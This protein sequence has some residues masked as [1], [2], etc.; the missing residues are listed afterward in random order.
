MK[1]RSVVIAGLCCVL[2][3]SAAEAQ[4]VNAFPD[5]DDP[6]HVRAAMFED[7]MFGNHWNEGTIMQHVIFPP[8]GLERPLVGSQEDCCDHT[9]NF[10][11]AWSL[12]YAL[13]GDPAVRERAD[14]LMDGILK[15]EKV[16]GVPGWVA[17]SFNKTE[18]PLWHEQAYFFPMEW[19]ASAS[20]PGYR[21]QGDLSSDK[22][23][24]LCWAMGIYHDF[25]AGETQRKA[26]SDF[27]DRFV[28]RVVD[29]NFRL[30]DVDNKM[31]LWGNFCPD[32][33]HEPL[34]SLEML[35]G[36]R[37]AYQL[38]KKDRY[39]R[40]YRKLIEDYGYAD[41][42][43]MAKLLWPEKWRTSWDDHLAVKSLFSLLRYETDRGLRQKYTM[44][45]NRHWQDWKNRD[46]DHPSTLFLVMNYAVLTKTEIDREKLTAGLKGMWGFDRRVRAFRIPDGAGGTKTVE[47][48]EE[49]SATSMLLTYWFGRHYGFVEA[50]W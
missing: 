10:L 41:D 39:F 40:A 33:P 4:R 43:I 36:L 14:A 15:L 29:H 26:A 1:T 5:R 19:H 30:V 50:D 38:T 11:A 31:T 23:V 45:L 35:A 12:R 21:W 22:F 6:L 2:M 34:N 49:G 8:A 24:S 13:T 48:A 42:A 27:I 47:S 3:M 18:E 28:G 25:C 44:C 7:L 16:T 9:C 20:M 37:V 17:R 46:W 32:L